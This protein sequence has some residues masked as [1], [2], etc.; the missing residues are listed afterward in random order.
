M[1]W[2]ASAVSGFR[3]G[4]SN[5]KNARNRTIS[6]QQKKKCSTAHSTVQQLMPKEKGGRGAE[7]GERRKGKSQSHSKSYSLCWVLNK[8]LGLNF[9]KNKDH[10]IGEEMFFSRYSTVNP[11]GESYQL[12]HVCGIGKSC[13]II[14]ISSANE[15]CS[16]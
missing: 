7:T 3:G 14:T 6:N 15:N 2:S 12:V 5:E 9:E 1:R 16:R 4:K 8:E 11:E 10:R 13:I